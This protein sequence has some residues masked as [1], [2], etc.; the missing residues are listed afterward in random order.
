MPSGGGKLRSAVASFTLGEAKKREEARFLSEYF[1]RSN[2][3]N[4]AHG[5]CSHFSHQE[6][7]PVT[8]T[9]PNRFS[10][11]LILS[12]RDFR[13]FASNKNFSLIRISYPL[14]GAHF[15]WIVSK[16]LADFSSSFCLS[17]SE[18]YP[19]SFSSTVR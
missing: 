11:S 1:H 8:I 12:R 3:V 7:S 5:I 17:A 19:F 4:F 6:T 13:V 10:L 15:F 14:R 2:E 18:S 9:P 16:S